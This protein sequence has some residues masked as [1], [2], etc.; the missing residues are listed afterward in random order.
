MN[1]RRPVIGMTVLVC[2]LL[3]L[4]G[5]TGYGAAP[6]DP[7]SLLTPDEV[8]AVLGVEVDQ[9]QPMGSK[10]CAWIPPGQPNSM[11][12]KKV[13]V[14]MLDEQ[15]FNLAKT[16]VGRKGITK[17]PVKGVGDDAVYVTVARMAAT[18]SVKQ[19]SLAFTVHVY[20][21]PLDQI[22]LKEKELALKILARL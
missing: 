13:V 14:T 20:G 3:F 10:T 19:G 1:S 22:E 9:G 15:A 4:G 11:N 2:V 6:S 12:A 8:K 18:L 5:R 16:A 17:T 7:C 21:F